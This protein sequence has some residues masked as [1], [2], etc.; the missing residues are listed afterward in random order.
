LLAL[1]LATFYGIIQYLDGKYFLPNPE[2]GLDPFIWRQAFGNRIFSTFGNPNFYGDFLVALAPTT[3]ALFVWKK[4]PF[5]LILWLMT[6]FNTYVTY[7]KGAWI[8]F[9][10]GTVF[11]ALFYIIFFSHLKSVNIRK[12][13]VISIIGIIILTS[14]GVY[15]Q[16]TQR[17]DSAKFRVN[18]WLSCWEMINTSPV[19]GTGLGTFYV[20]Y[21]AWRRPQIFFIE[22]KH[23]TESDHPENEYLEVWYDEGTVGFGIFLWLIVTFAFFG[24]RGLK[25]FSTPTI[26]T[27]KRGRQKEISEDVRAYYLLGL[28][29]GWLGSLVHNTVCVSLRFVSSGTYLWLLVGLIGTLVINNPLPQSSKEKN[30][31]TA[32][33]ALFIIF[34]FW[35][36]NFLWWKMVSNVAIS[37]AVIFFVIGVI[38]ESG[39]IKKE[40]FVELSLKNNNILSKSIQVIFVIICFFVCTTFRG[41]FVGDIHHNIAIFYSKQANWSEALTNYNIVAKHNPGFIMCHYFMGNVFNDRWILSR[42]L[43]PEWGDKETDDPWTNI[44]PGKK[45]RVDPER[46]ISKYEDVWKLAP[47]Y[48]QSHHQ[49]GVVYSKLA[50]YFK[51]LGDN[52]KRDFYWEKAL[53]CFWKYHK[54]D[55]IFSVNYQ[56][57]AA[58][59]VQKN[60]L[61]TAEKIYKAHL[62]TQWLCQTPKDVIPNPKTEEEKQLLENLQ[63]QFEEEKDWVCCDYHKRQHYLI[64]T[65]DWAKRR[66]NEYSESYLQ[67]GNI[68]Y[69]QHNFAEAEK[70]FRR[71][72]D[73]DKNNFQAWKNIIILYRQTNQTEKLKNIVQQYQ[74][75]FPQDQTLSQLGKI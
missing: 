66:A 42:E 18:T 9:A 1:F 7:S 57:I 39:K 26:V 71:A 3:L 62:F 68:K 49:A 40:E 61:A 48:V 29:S 32:T 69:M 27:D 16:L 67:L 15:F 41:Y 64:A 53:E 55:P 8:G 20:T 37:I 51:N 46:S 24:I 12:Y 19:F 13:I 34:V 54:I 70:Y 58:I 52:Q 22:A 30:V 10:A 43:H 6:A 73:R 50:E 5:Y 74:K 25:N 75:F 17:T 4:N 33:M 31:V 44:D 60:D 56:R 11:F 59:Y 45:G 72:I 23:N 65:E 36:V 2:P 47:N 21:P 28:I 35:L 63:K 38:L 14:Y